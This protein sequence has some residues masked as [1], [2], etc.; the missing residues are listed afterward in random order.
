MDHD[1]WSFP[2]F[3]SRRVRRTVRRSAAV[4]VAA[5]LAGTLAGAAIWGAE[6]AA[7]S[8]N[9]IT[10][11]NFTGYGFD[12]CEAPTQG[13]MDAWIRSSPYK[14]A[15][16][17]ISG[18]SRGCQ[19]QTHLTPDWVT[20]Q[21]RA[22]WH[23]LPITL[24]PQ[25]SCTNRDR[26]QHQV[27]ISAN[28]KNA[29]LAAKNQG[30]YEANKTVA[31]A[32]D[33]G[34]RSGST[35]FYD[36]EAFP[37]SNT[38]CRES[39]LSFLSSWT[40]QL[41]ILGYASGIYSSAASGM[42]I[43]DDARGGGRF[44]MPDQIWIADW[45]GRADTASS[46]I[47]K[48]GWMPKGRVHQYMG[49]HNETWGGVTINI[50]R[51]W[52]DLQTPARFT[53]PELRVVTTEKSPMRA[54]KSAEWAVTVKNAG[55][56]SAGVVKVSSTV[57]DASSL[58]MTAAGGSGFSRS[59]KTGSLNLGI[60]AAGASRTVKVTGTLAPTTSGQVLNKSWAQYGNGG[61]GGYQS[62]AP[63]QNNTTTTNDTD[64]C[65][66]IYTNGVT[67]APAD[68]RLVTTEAAPVRAGEVAKW[69]VTAK[70]VG[71][72]PAP[73][74]TVMTSPRNVDTGTLTTSAPGVAGGTRS[75]SVGSI[76]L[77]TLAP[78][79]TKAVSVSAK[80]PDRT[81]GQVLNKSW[82]RWGGGSQG[83]QATRPCQNNT[84]TAN[85]TDSCDY[86]YTNGVVPNTGNVRVL[87]YEASRI[88]AGSTATW[89]I[90]VR[91]VGRATATGIK[92]NTVP[93]QVNPRS[94]KMVAGG[95][96]HFTRSGTKGTLDIG[97]LASGA[98]K[99][100]IVTAAVP[101][102]TKGQ[103]L[104]KSWVQ[105]GDGSLGY[106]G[107]RAC[108]NNTWVSRDTDGCDYVYTNGL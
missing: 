25:A 79:A 71:G 56:V 69:T 106:Q 54:G 50:D 63:C 87:A 92:V 21:L 51:N 53:R 74:L 103:V 44:T 19:K 86:V 104:D 16:I 65:D 55:R 35:M 34:L 82:A 60:L 1:P 70:N 105:W 83:Y 40:R 47:R 95:V 24:G 101:A 72:S 41:H 85:D 37:T 11:G 3:S 73:G 6:P 57:A 91:N 23:L 97:S 31:K 62:T 78:G 28:S 98:T 14:A 88:R 4:L 77:G 15:G 33:L 38:A 20:H 22:G 68:V 90:Y 27:R 9:P 107:A 94:L 66:Y 96:S 93:T 12:Q 61:Y 108:Q 42:K 26:Y 76:A 17:Y 7:A 102:G 49:G 5:S 59:G 30:V 13:A 2:M 32:K 45:N 46:Y 8:S 10:P 67:R 43:L 18:D 58:R 100:V 84:T 36:I 89:R 39:A 64:A 81:S 99:I 80:V 48:D 29:Y 75:G 52:L